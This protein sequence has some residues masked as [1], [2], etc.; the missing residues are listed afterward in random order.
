MSNCEIRYQS[1]RT[2]NASNALNA[3]PP[4]REAHDKDLV[5]HAQLP[6]L[7]EVT[8]PLELIL[9]YHLNTT[10]YSQ[11]TCESKKLY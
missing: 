2:G 1:Q 6:I 11:F 10:L 8:G 3:S 5:L 9:P 7:H 4:K